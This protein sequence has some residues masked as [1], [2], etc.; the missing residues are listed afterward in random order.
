M[1]AQ[2]PALPEDI[3]YHVF[4]CFTRR[5]DLVPLMLVRRTWQATAERLQ[6]MDLVLN[7]PIFEGAGDGRAVRC[8]TTLTQRGSAANAVRH[9]AVTG[10]LTADTTALLLGALTKTTRLLSLNIQ[11]YDRSVDGSFH[12]S[13]RAFCESALFLPN[14]AAFNTNDAVNAQV[15]P[16]GR[17]LSVFGLPCIEDAATANEIVQT[18]QRSTAPLSQLCLYIEAENMTAVDETMR[19]ICRMF[20]SLRVLVV[21]FRLPNA[22]DVTWD[23]IEVSTIGYLLQRTL[24]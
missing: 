19:T 3:L 21:Q 7:F 16:S 13:W 17:P 10:S 20:P 2:G 5:S 8:L 18:L 14:L 15:I 9:L 24:Y 4:S 6:Y 23:S 12:S 11:I 1:A 22:E